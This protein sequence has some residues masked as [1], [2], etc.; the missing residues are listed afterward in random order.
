M[1]RPSSGAEILCALERHRISPAAKD[2]NAMVEAYK[3]K[4]SIFVVS[5]MANNW[6]MRRRPSQGT[7]KA[8]KIRISAKSHGIG[9]DENIFAWPG[10]V[11]LLLTV[12]EAPP[13]GFDSSFEPI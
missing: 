3:L 11:E 13:Y 7:A 8:K 12:M 1:A 5:G 9:I 10:Q 4:R 6:R 2:W